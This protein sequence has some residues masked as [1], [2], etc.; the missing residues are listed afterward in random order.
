[1]EELYNNTATK[2][3]AFLEEI[4]K[5]SPAFYETIQQNRQSQKIQIIYTQ[6]DRHE[7]NHP[8]FKS[9]Y[10]NYSPNDYLYPASTVKMPV[11]LLALQR[12]NELNI[13]GLNKNTTLITEAAYSG[14]TA[15]YNDPASLDG[16]PTIANYIKKIFLISDNDAYNRL[17]EFLGQEYIN[18]QLQKMGYIQAEILHRLSIPLSPDENRHTNP[19]KFLNADGKIIYEQA[20][21]ANNST[22]SKR[23]DVLGKAYYKGETL[24]NEPL[25]FSSKNRMNLEDLTQVLKATLFPNAVSPKQRF[26]LTEADYRFV[27]QYLSQLPTETTT[28]AINDSIANWPAYVKF[29]LYGSQKDPLPRSIRIFNKVGDAYG[30]LIDVAYIID[31]DKKIEFMLSARIYCNKDG[32]LNDDQYDYESVG[33][34]FM[35]QLGQLLY[36]YE[37]KR[38]RTRQPDLSDF[39]FQYEK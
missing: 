23:Q 2:N 14:Q 5:M 11:A 34:P 29:L 35:K 19:V 9:F 39:L 12:L 31:L 32:I 36:N 28:I 17:Y 1:M 22:Y 15:V 16:R 38:K 25:N 6:I 13:K 18:T 24:I 20:M 8:V 37:L 30:G 27:R 33:F 21:Q 7:N 3:E 10:Y 26:N 4:L